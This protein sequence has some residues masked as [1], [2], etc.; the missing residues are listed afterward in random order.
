MKKQFIIIILVIF[1][2]LAGIFYA[3]QVYAPQYHTTALHVGNVV[4]AMLSIISYYLVMGQIK[5]R[6]Q[7]FIRGVYSSSFL[8]LMVCIIAIVTYAMVNKAT[9]HKPTLFTLFGIYAVYSIIENWM[10]S[11]LAREVK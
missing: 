5:S 3:M 4:M 10:L 1:V 11:R 2:V 7:A 9:L 8:K 6:P